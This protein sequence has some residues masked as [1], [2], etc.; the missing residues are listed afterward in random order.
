MAMDI[1]RCRA[2]SA[3]SRWLATGGITSGLEVGVTATASWMTWVANES[4]MEWTVIGT[5]EA[6]A[7]EA[8]AEDD[9]PADALWGKS[10]SF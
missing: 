1:S 2:A 4:A 7:E 3:S 10:R 6:V 9:G 5:V 8:V